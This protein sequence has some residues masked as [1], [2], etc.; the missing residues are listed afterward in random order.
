MKAVQDAEAAVFVHEA[1]RP[2]LE[3]RCVLFGPPVAQ[4]A[5]RI[6]LPALVVEPCV[7]SWPMTDP[8]PPRFTA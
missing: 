5:Q 1:L 6:K 4:I 7:S 3:R 8:M 2:L